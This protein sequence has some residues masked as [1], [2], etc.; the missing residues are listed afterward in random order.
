MREG[1]GG[2]GVHRVCRGGRGCRVCAVRRG[3][4]GSAEGAGC[5]EGCARGTGVCRTEGAECA[6][7]VQ[8][9]CRVLCVVYRGWCMVGVRCIVFSVRCVLR[10]LNSG[11]HHSTSVLVT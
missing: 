6:P 10:G 9:V 5:T 11:C 3:C 2:E 8:R 7:R 1:E 4:R